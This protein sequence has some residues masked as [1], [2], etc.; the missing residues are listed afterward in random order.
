MTE[1]D[2]SAVPDPGSGS[3]PEPTRQFPAHEGP[4]AAAYSQWESPETGSA[5]PGQQPGQQYPQAGYPQS[6][7]QQPGYAQ[8]EYAQPDYTQPGYAQPG[9]QSGPNRFAGAQQHAGAAA[10]VATD[11]VRR[12]KSMPWQE[13][14]MRL[15]GAMAVFAGLLTLMSCLFAWWA[16]FDRTMGD[17]IEYTITPFR[18]ISASSGSRWGD[19]AAMNSLSGSELD[20]ARSFTISIGILLVI[21]ALCMVAG[22]LFIALNRAQIIGASLM[23]LGTVFLGYARVPAETV[24]SIAKLATDA[25]TSMSDPTG[26]YSELFGSLIPEARFGLGLSTFAL[27]LMTLALLIYLGMIIYRETIRIRRWTA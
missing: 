23:L 2:R 20:T 15:P 11:T 7:Y 1:D 16:A 13:R 10:A 4:P 27:V 21:A 18:G 17:M 22:G 3:G 8:P 25:G 19:M 5:A 9:Q 24:G 12:V 14:V 26:L 6:G